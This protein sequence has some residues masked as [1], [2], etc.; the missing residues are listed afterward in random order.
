MMQCFYV[1]NANALKSIK[2]VDGGGS[3]GSGGS[4]R[5][6]RRQKNVLFLVVAGKVT[7]S[8]TSLFGLGDQL[9]QPGG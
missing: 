8:S 5:G 1:V 9:L 7:A 2:P 6:D 3:G 4:G